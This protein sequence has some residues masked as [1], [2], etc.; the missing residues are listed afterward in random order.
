M[1][2]DRTYPG[3]CLCNAVRFEITG[4]FEGF[5]LCHCG[6]CRKNSGSAHAANLFSSTAR[7]DWLS[8][9]DGVRTYAVP[10]TRHRRSFCLQCGSALP[11]LH[12]DD[13]LLV[14]P[15]GSLDGAAGIRPNAH[16]FSAD[17]ADWDNRLED[18]PAFDAF[19]G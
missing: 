16:I 5:F 7:I 15:A 17:R 13:T 14:V 8:G 18:I 1:T 11:S 10:D 3:S 9:A 6:R 2:D 19:P 12:M 4:A